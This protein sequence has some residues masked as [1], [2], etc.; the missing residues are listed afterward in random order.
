MPTEYHRVLRAGRS[1]IWSHSVYHAVSMCAQTLVTARLWASV[2]VVPNCLCGM[3]NIWNHSVYY[4]VGRSVTNPRSQSFYCESRH[5]NGSHSFPTPTSRMKK[6]SAFP[7]LLVLLLSA[8]GS[9]V[10]S[11]VLP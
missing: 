2:G 1:N 6:F 3:S 9:G 4:T 10:R 5:S 8:W 11:G 7:M